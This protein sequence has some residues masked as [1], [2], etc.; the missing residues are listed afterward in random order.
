MSTPTG[1]D[2]GGRSHHAS[3]GSAVAEVGIGVEDNLGDAGGGFAVL[4]LLDGGFAEGLAD[5]FVSNHGDGLALGVV[6]R[7][8]GG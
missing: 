2:V 4:D 5:R 8:E 1:V 3:D 7:D 6:G